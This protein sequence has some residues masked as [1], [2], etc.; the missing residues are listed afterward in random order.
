MDAA[1]N[2]ISYSGRG[3]VTI[4]VELILMETNPPG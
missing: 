4:G 1:I 3:S 2:G